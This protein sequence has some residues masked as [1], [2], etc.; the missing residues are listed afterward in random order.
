[1]VCAEHITSRMSQSSIVVHPLIR[2]TLR[3]RWR[4]KILERVRDLPLTEKGIVV[5]C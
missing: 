3:F 2:G 5:E 4:A 1:M